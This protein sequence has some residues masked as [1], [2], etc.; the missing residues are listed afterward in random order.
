ME[1]R[2]LTEQP[3]PVDERPLCRCHGVP[4]VRNGVRA[5]SQRWR[6]RVVTE[7]RREQWREARRRRYWAAKDRG[8]C[9]RCGAPLLSDAYCWDCL[10]QMEVTRWHRSPIT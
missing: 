7:R 1:L 5:E 2:Y 4:M 6:C 8:V 3:Q 10:D 9:T